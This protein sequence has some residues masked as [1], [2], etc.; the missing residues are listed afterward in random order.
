M[1]CP[2]GNPNPSNCVKCK[3][4]RAVVPPQMGGG[5]PQGGLPQVP[6][7]NLPQ[8]ARNVVQQTSQGRPLPRQ[9]QVPQGT[10]VPPVTRGAPVQGNTAHQT[11]NVVN[12][13]GPAPPPRR[14]PPPPPPPAIVKTGPAHILAFEADLKSRTGTF[15]K[16][17]S[18]TLDLFNYLETTKHDPTPFAGASEPLKVQAAKAKCKNA[19]DSRLAKYEPALR[20]LVRVWGTGKPYVAEVGGSTSPVVP[21]PVSSGSWSKSK[22]E[23]WINDVA[24]EL[25]KFKPMAVLDA[26]AF[27]GDINPSKKQEVLDRAAKYPVPQG[28]AGSTM[29]D[30]FMSQQSTA[31]SI[32]ALKS[33]Y[34]KVHSE[35]RGVC[36]SFARAAAYVLTVGRPSGPRIELVSYRNPKKNRIAHVFVVLGRKGGL[37]GGKLPDKSNWG[38]DTMIV[39]AWL[40]AMGWG[41]VSDVDAFPKKGYLTNLSVLMERPAS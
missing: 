22:I 5:L 17:R 4:A 8:T 32:T 28:S 13:R 27:P 14:Q 2:H 35:K 39:D 7:R 33:V 34:E 15:T 40:G 1:A 29:G 18:S 19:A 16:S 41:I 31:W 23:T 26:G 21:A 25:D 6:A 38:S 12:P 9:V 37:E 30:A 11:T 36:T 10:Q 24:G 3:A 20:A